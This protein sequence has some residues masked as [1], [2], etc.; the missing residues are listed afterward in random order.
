MCESLQSVRRLK[1]DTQGLALFPAAATREEE[2]AAFERGAQST[3]E[4]ATYDVAAR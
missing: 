4:E 3:E 2:G 1:G